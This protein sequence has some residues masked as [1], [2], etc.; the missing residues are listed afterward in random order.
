MIKI[1]LI[2]LLAIGFVLADDN[3]T[4]S[5]PEGNLT[6]PAVGISELDNNSSIP[7]QNTNAVSVGSESNI[8]NPDEKLKNEIITY[9]R[10]RHINNEVIN[11]PFI[12]VYPKTQADV[13]YIQKVE[14]VVLTLKG[15]FEN[16]ANI[17]NQWVEKGGNVEGW[18][19]VDI[20]KDKVR[21]KFRTSSRTLSIIPE[22]VKIKEEIQY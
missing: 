12:Y 10:P 19:V 11:D 21:L 22:K 15:I 14:Q 18:E 16:K 3:S 17:N 9:D 13:E 6:T 1:L 5:L 2:P 4:A 7:D 8:I 20:Q